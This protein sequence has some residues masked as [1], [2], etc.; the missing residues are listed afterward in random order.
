[1]VT[2]GSAKECQRI[3][4]DTVIWGKAVELS[5]FLVGKSV[6]VDFEEPQPI[7]ERFD[8]RELR[9]RIASLTWDEAKKL[10]IGKST[11]HYLRR[12]AAS[13][14]PFVVYKKIHSRLVLS[15]DDRQRGSC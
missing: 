14:R 7:L 15:A 13:P 9:E 3:K 12:N 2:G 4:W 5:R 1:M 11:L 8:S 6:A 10:G